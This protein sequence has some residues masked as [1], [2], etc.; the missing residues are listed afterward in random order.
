M[1]ALV[2]FLFIV[3]TQ[4]NIA[5]AYTYTHKVTYRYT[6]DHLTH[7]SAIPPAWLT[8]AFHLETLLDFVPE[9]ATLPLTASVL[10]PGE[11]VRVYT[12]WDRRTDG[13]TRDRSTWQAVTRY[14]TAK[15]Y[16]RPPPTAIG[17]ERSLPHSPLSNAFEAAHTAI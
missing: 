16:A 15:R 14:R 8:M 6:T 7:A 2:V 17:R 5:H 1:I 11:S 4:T 3:R 10:T 9:D 13:R 12:R